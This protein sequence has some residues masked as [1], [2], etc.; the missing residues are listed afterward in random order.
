MASAC[1]SVEKY[2]ECLN[3][4]PLG[5]EP[6][7]AV[8]DRSASRCVNPR[9]FGAGLADEKEAEGAVRAAKSVLE[10]SYRL[11]LSVTPP[12]A[13]A[14]TWAEK[15]RLGED[16]ANGRSE[17][18]ASVP[19]QGFVPLIAETR[20]VPSPVASQPGPALHL[21][22]ISFLAFYLVELTE[23]PVHHCKPP[24]CCRWCDLAV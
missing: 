24:P 9:L 17:P 18:S 7:T 1:R 4:T 10:R 21:R 8:D 2:E 22:A 16:K 14:Q 3:S 6:E 5:S 15:T 12:E 19:I 23:D 13:R 11:A 20:P